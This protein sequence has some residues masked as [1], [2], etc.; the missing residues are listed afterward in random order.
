MET[1]NIGKDEI[2]C[3]TTGCYLI[4]DYSRRRWTSPFLL[5]DELKFIQPHAFTPSSYPT[6]DFIMSPP[7]E[8]IA[9]K[10][11]SEWY[12]PPTPISSHNSGSKRR[13]LSETL[14]KICVICWRW[15]WIGIE[16]GGLM[17]YALPGVVE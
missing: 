7:L 14:S 13:K 15:A 2:E 6:H 10:T 3:G 9:F 8:A 16:F 17:H 4:G 12:N 1:Y 11:P 5:M